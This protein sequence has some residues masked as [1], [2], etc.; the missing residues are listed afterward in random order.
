MEQFGPEAEQVLGI[1]EVLTTERAH[2]MGAWDEAHASAVDG[3]IAEGYPGRDGEGLAGDGPIGLILMK[4]L[5]ATP[6]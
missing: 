5:L 3:D 6:L 4:L 1:P 2:G